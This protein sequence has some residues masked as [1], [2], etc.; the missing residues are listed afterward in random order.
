MC[1]KEEQYYQVIRTFTLG[2]WAAQHASQF[3]TLKKINKQFQKLRKQG[4]NELTL[5]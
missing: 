4:K 5:S 1:Y 2:M 3:Y